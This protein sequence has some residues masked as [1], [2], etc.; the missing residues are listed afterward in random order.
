MKQKT[1]TM[2]EK[3]WIYPG[4]HANWHFTSISKEQSQKIKEMYGKNAKGFGSLPVTVTIGKTTWDTSVFP[5]RRAGT[6]LLP[7]KAKVRQT[8][9]IEAGEA[10]TFS[11][12]VRV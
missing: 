12:S 6:Y 7:L 2:T 9:D 8:E 5:D 10:V 3:V 4:D 1:Y 11:I